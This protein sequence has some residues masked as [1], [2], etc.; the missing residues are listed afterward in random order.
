MDSRIETVSVEA[1][2]LDDA[3]VQGHLESKK[4][5]YTPGDAA[6][7]LSIGR[8][9]LFALMADGTLPSLL[10]GRSRRIRACDLEAFVDGQGDPRQRYDR[11]VGSCGRGD[12]A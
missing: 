6:E 11:C 3:R 2:L 12:V 7:S 4:L 5:L 8:T 9:K 1:M 10:I